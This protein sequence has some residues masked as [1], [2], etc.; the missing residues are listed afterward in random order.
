MRR[1]SIILFVSLLSVQAIAWEHQDESLKTVKSRTIYRDL[2]SIDGV[3]W[4]STGRPPN[5]K[6]RI[7]RLRKKVIVHRDTG[8]VSSS[9]IAV[10]LTQRKFNSKKHK[11]GYEYSGTPRS[12]FLTKIDHR[13]FWGT[14]GDKPHVEISSFVVVIKSDTV[15]I[16][17]EAWN[18]MYEPT[19]S[20]MEVYASSDKKRSYIVMMNSDGAG[21]YLVAWCF[22][23]G[24][25]I[26]R[27]VDYGW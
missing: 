9:W 12:R 4:P 19:L 7:K 27:V 24:K 23:D 21:A 25:Y 22:I 1:P 8:T 17:P 10:R 3:L 11:L 26:R 15:H 14:D 5:L 20:N 2:L 13:S 6:P 18:D 16:P